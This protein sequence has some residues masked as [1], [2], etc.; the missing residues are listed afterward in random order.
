MTTFESI[1]FD[2]PTQARHG[3]FVLLDKYSFESGDLTVGV[4]PAGRVEPVLEFKYEN[5]IGLTMKE[6][7]FGCDGGQ[8]TRGDLPDATQAE[9][10]RRSFLFLSRDSQTFKFIRGKVPDS[11]RDSIDKHVHYHLTLREHELDFIA[12]EAY[13]RHLLATGEEK[14]GEPENAH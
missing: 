2:L 10:R 5:V 9:F 6:N 14:I 1:P 13:E 4:C 8:I 7:V 3:G 11:F 12:S